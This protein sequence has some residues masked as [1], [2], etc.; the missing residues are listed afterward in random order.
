MDSD[1]LAS[2]LAIEFLRREKTQ[3]NESEFLDRYIELRAFFKKSLRE[4]RPKLKSV[5]DV[6]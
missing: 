5:F 6:M 1:E 3:M 2:K 4:R